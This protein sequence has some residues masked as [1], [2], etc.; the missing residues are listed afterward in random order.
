MNKYT[1]VPFEGNANIVQLHRDNV[2]LNCP[3]RT[4]LMY[5][6]PKSA[7]DPTPVIQVI[8]IP[9]SSECPFFEQHE[10]AAAYAAGIELILC[11]GKTVEISN[12]Q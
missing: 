5:A 10:Y 6:A 4:P 11:D 7:I 8:N 12:E 1:L 2:P 3:K 9:C